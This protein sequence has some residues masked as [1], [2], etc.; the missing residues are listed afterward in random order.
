[1]MNR[2]RTGSR[3]SDWAKTGWAA[4]AVAGLVATAHIALAAAPGVFN[5]RDCGATGDG[6]TLDTEAINKAVE[7][8]AAAGGGQVLFPPG[9]YLSGTVHLK[10]NVTLVFD[11]GAT[12]VGSTDLAHY[13]NFTPP[14][15]TPES[16]WPRWHRAL[17]L[18][19][20]VEHVA[21][22]GLGLIDGNKVFDPRGEEKMR[23]PHT[24]LLG[25]C[26]DV[27]IRDVSVKDS[28]NYAIMLEFC[29]QVDVR[30]VKITGGW[31]GVHFRGWPGRPCRDVSIVGC[32]FYTGD[33]SIAGR[34]WEN[35]LVSDCIV[36]S[37][38]NGVRL[39]GPAT[40]LTIHSCLFYGPGVHPHRTSNRHNMLSGII[41]QPGCWDATEG[42][43]D[44][45]LLSDIT[46]KNVASPL[47]VWVKSGN[48][49]GQIT[50]SRL[51][52]TGVYRAAASVENWAETP[53]ERVVFRDV[54]IEYDGGGALEQG[55]MPI[56]PPGAD[57]RPLPV[58]GFYARNV[59]HVVLEDVRLTC[60]RHDLRPVLVCDGLE[61]LTLDSFKFPR[62][63]DAHDVLV[64][65]DV[66]EVRVH[67]ADVPVVQPRYTELRLLSDDP[68]GRFVAGKPF[69]AT[70]AVE[71][72][73]QE[74]LGKVELA[75]ADHKTVNWLWLRSGEKRD[76]VFRGLTVP[77]PGTCEVRV[78]SLTRSLVV[79][80]P[81]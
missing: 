49:G 17:I 72:E 23:G 42:D 32:Q 4:L 20:G 41:L 48:K 38:C 16:R 10:S 80:Q 81:Q 68:A 71:N 69:S 40:H 9:K 79:E 70:V 28:A 19:D 6:K 66:N 33:D 53:V 67:P 75:V 55:Q 60:A 65:N 74:G 13:Q 12:L 43:L 77:A 15:G 14:E 3:R 34:Y 56:K 2:K 61:R 25:N 29:Q 51:A 46:M 37:S 63:A 58:W 18:G 39:I 57:A 5:V 7:A 64:L 27:T 62:L 35:V 26:R 73:A 54:N 24:I 21:I 52:A 36:N 30:S 59:N 22:T 47:T 78:G 45:V 50:V 11:A 76:V 44:D 1:M 31:D 8:S